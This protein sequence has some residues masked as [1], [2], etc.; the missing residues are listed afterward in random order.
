[1]SVY[2]KT[3]R[4]RSKVNIVEFGEGM[5]VVRTSELRALLPKLL[6]SCTASKR[7]WAVTYY[8][9]TV[10]FLVPAT[11]C[12]GFGYVVDMQ[13]SEFRDRLNEAW[14]MLQGDVDAVCISYHSQRRAMLVAPRHAGALG[15]DTGELTLMEVA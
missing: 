15:I 6:R 12:P 7:L 2:C 4:K 8:G 14:E 1:M 9:N 3:L 11:D 10:G 5:K 13:Q